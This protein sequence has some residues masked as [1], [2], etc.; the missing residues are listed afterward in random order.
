MP[1]GSV[2][3]KRMTRWPRKGR[4]LL[5]CASPNPPDANHI[6][7]GYNSERIN[8]DFSDSTRAMISECP[9]ERKEIAE[10]LEY[11]LMEWVFLFRKSVWSVQSVSRCKPKKQWEETC[12]RGEGQ[13]AGGKKLVLSVGFML[14]VGNLDF[15]LFTVP[16]SLRRP[17][18]RWRRRALTQVGFLLFR[19]WQ[20][21]PYHMTLPSWMR[22]S[23]SICQKMTPRLLVAPKQ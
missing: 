8:A 5:G 13:G 3:G 21:E 12:F 19:R 9:A 6:Y 10:I 15:S 7:S 22:P 2:S 17:A 18:L 20:S 4:N 1:S 16:F 14:K 11:L 23:W